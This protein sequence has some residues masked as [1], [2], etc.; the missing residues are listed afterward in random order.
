MR[1]KPPK[2]SIAMSSKLTELRVQQI[3]N[4]MWHKIISNSGAKKLNCYFQHHKLK[5]WGCISGGISKIFSSCATMHS[6]LWLCTVAQRYTKILIFYLSFQLNN[7]YS[8][9]LPP[10]ALQLEHISF[11]FPLQFFS[12]SFFLF[13]LLFLHGEIKD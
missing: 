6:H 2:V 11:I 3:N 12:L 13:P 5:N 1:H 8:H 10:V 7:I 4:L 9:L